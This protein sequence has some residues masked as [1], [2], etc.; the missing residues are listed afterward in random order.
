MD[1]GQ[2]ETTIE[3]GGDED[4]IEFK[5]VRVAIARIKLKRI[6]R[7]KARGYV[8]NEI[9]VTNPLKGRLC[10]CC[11]NPVRWQGKC[12]ECIWAECFL[13]LEGIL[14]DAEPDGGVKPDE[15]DIKPADEYLKILGTLYEQNQTRI[16]EEKE[17]WKKIL[18]GK[19]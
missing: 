16:V 13:W 15:G 1:F 10:T 17:K 14:P 8:Q 9:K 19:N 12:N 11:G 3:P 7:G 5:D 2:H 6:E 4:G 18:D